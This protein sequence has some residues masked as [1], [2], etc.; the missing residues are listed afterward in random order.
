[1]LPA[2]CLKR[3]INKRVGLVLEL[4]IRTGNSTDNVEDLDVYLSGRCSIGDD[5]KRSPPINIPIFEGFLLIL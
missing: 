1:M 5:R 2:K 4:A 3:P